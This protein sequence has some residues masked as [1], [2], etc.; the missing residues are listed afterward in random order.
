MEILITNVGSEPIEIDA[1]SWELKEYRDAHRAAELT[2]KCSRKVPITRYA[3][4]IAS[5]GRRV[6]FRGYDPKIAIRFYA[7][8]D[9]HRYSHCYVV[10][11]VED[12]WLGLDTQGVNLSERI[13]K[14]ITEL[15]MWKLCDTPEEV[16]AM[17][18]RGPP[19]ISGEDAIQPKGA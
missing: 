15:E 4:V 8:V 3:H 12:G 2:I 18:R 14:V 7:Y 5:E 13:G 6:L 10:V 19:V 9:G 11:P 16:F 17:D 1:D